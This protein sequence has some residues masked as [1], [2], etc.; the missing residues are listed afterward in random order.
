MVFCYV[1]S[2]ME[3]YDLKNVNF[4]YYCYITIML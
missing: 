2:V 4:V 3:V 1:F